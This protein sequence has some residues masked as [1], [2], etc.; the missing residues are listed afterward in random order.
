MGGGIE[1]RKISRK[2]NDRPVHS[3]SLDSTP[4]GAYEI[5]F[6]AC[7][8][9]LQLVKRMTCQPEGWE[10]AVAASWSIAPKSQQI[11]A[12]CSSAPLEENAAPD[13][14]LLQRISVVFT[15][16]LH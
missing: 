7:T 12:L 5:Q 11:S 4:R 9:S 13:L 15:P 16:L 14:R 2:I 10:C 6:T 3:L 1:T 8:I